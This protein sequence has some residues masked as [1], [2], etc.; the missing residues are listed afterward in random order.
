M[1]FRA[2]R[3]RQYS[4]VYG[5]REHHYNIPC[6]PGTSALLTS[7]FLVCDS[8]D[9]L[10]NYTPI[11][12]KAKPLVLCDLRFYIISVCSPGKILL[13]NSPEQETGHSLPSGHDLSYLF[14]IIIMIKQLKDL[15]YILQDI[16]LK[17]QFLF[18]ITVS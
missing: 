17:K 14:L 2:K 13:L 10:K 8:L 16:F 4:G 9:I 7:H 18:L 11:D 6:C 1:T 15:R 12:D 3:K 5:V